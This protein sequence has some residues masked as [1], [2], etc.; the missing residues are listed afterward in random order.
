MGQGDLDTI[1]NCKKFS[2]N[3][4]IDDVHVPQLELN[5]VEEISGDLIIQ[6]STDLRSFSAPQLRAV[7]GELKVTNHT[8]LEKVDLPALMEAKG[9]TLA[10]LPALEK[11]QFPAGLSKVEDMRIEDTRAP[12]IEGFHPESMNSFTLTNNN[13]M[14]HFDFSS[15][16]ELKGSMYVIANGH[17]LELQNATFRNLAQ[18]DVPALSRVGSDIS[19]HQNEFTNLNLDGLELIGG[20]LTIANN[21]KLSETSFKNLAKIGGAL[22]VGNNTQLRTIDGFPK[23]G[24]VDGTIDLAGSF[25]SYKLPLLQDVRGGMRLQ[26]SSSQFP[27]SEIEKRMKGDNVVKGTVW[28][29]ASSLQENEMT[30][31][32]GQNVGIPDKISSG[33]RGSQSSVNT[34]NLS[35]SGPVPGSWLAL[36]IGLTF[37]SLGI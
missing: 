24:E 4:M 11:I 23:L 28:S 17:T 26:T 5:G 9:L 21:D 32:I 15:V 22:S 29:C 14:K 3:I 33:N 12:R 7:K 34:M 8:I 20:T 19:F 1:K 25:E 37:I 30:P 31:T 36:V 18:L 35:D 6:G 2:G 10:I 16:K 27:C 13:Y